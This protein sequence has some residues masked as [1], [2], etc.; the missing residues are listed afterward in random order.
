MNRMLVTLF[1]CLA[2]TFCSHADDL[3]LDKLSF[4]DGFIPFYLDKDQ[5][6]IFLS[7]G[8]LDQEFLYLSALTSGVGSNDIGLDRG[9]LGDTRMVNFRKN[10]KKVFLVHKNMAFR[11]SSENVDEVQS[12]QDAF[13]ESILWGFDILQTKDG[14]LIV[15]ATDFYLRDTHGVAERLDQTNQ[16]TFKTDLSRSGLHL[17]M[18]KNFPQNTEVEA[19]ITVT[20]NATGN[21]LK[22]VAPTPNSVTVRQRHSFVE[23]PDN[24]YIP[25]EFD[26]RAGFGSISFMDFATPIDQPIIK[27]YIARHRL[28]KKDPSAA[29][30]EAIEPIIYY[31]DRGTPEPVRSALL[32]G[33][34]W[35][36][37][38]FEAAGF[39]NAFRIELAPE[40][41]D[42]LDVRYN[43]I[44]WIHRS[45][46]GWSYG[47]SIKD[48][49][50]GEILKGHVSLGSLRVRQDYLIAQGLLQP[51]EKGSA[52]DK[53]MLDLALARLR[54]LSAHEIG[55]TI[56][57]SHNFGS[58]AAGRS[59]VMDYPYPLATGNAVDIDLDKAYDSKIGAWDKWAIIYGYGYPDKDTDEN[60]FLKTTLEATYTAGYE[61]ISDADARDMSGVHPRSHLWDNGAS[62]PD[63]LERMLQ[64]R[65]HKMSSF[66]LNAIRTGQPEATLEEIFVP[67]YLMHRYQLEAVTKLIGGMDFNYKVK[68]D[69]QPQHSWVDAKDQQRALDSL[70]L[71]IMPDQLEVPAHIVALIP[72]RPFGY[73]RNRETFISRM[74]PVFDPIAP[75]ENIVD[76]VFKFVLETGRVNRI[77]VQNLQNESLLSL[78]EVLHTVGLVMFA[79]DTDTRLKNEIKMMVESKWVDHL[80]MLANNSHVSNSVRAIVRS[81]LKTLKDGGK[82]T[83]SKGLVRRGSKSTMLSM[84]SIYLAEKIQA[85]FDLSAEPSSQ[86]VIKVPDGSPIGMNSMTCDFD[87]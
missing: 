40:G 8:Q 57:L 41:M 82:V 23:L 14:R 73:S 45:T 69:N 67:L 25:R 79:T 60:T 87:Y 77:Y 71:A 74:G 6:K 17:P 10:G 7:I 19:T 33:G 70:M 47:A 31:L 72:P 48:P 68:G 28:V 27:R 32:D 34:N 52:V 58:S 37:E 53:G 38:A 85:F 39:K 66:N 65:R 4:N 50:T 75:A 2:T 29:M 30:S 26:P 1:V 63:E 9:Q 81:Q 59:S 21:F 24:K 16:G 3:N 5:G 86:T 44:Q 64:L 54:Q 55:H 35:W 56:G 22:S 15:D 61:F 76:M 13:A 36:N 83:G 84:H 62:A 20:G 18:V 46:R 80:I 51:F 12:I 42:F 49:R 78:D 11:A 43:V